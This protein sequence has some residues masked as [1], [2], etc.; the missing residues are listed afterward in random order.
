MAV[1]WYVPGKMNKQKGSRATFRSNNYRSRFP[2]AN[3]RGT[4]RRRSSSLAHAREKIS[5][6]MSPVFCRG[7]HE[8]YSAPT[9]AEQT[10]KGAVPWSVPGKTNQQ[11]GP[12]AHSGPIITDYSFPVPTA[13]EQTHDGAVPCRGKI[14]STS[15]DVYSTNINYITRIQKGTK[16]LPQSHRA[17][18]RKIFHMVPEHLAGSSSNKDIFPGTE[19]GKNSRPTV[20]G[21]T[22]GPST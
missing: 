20:P 9:S 16:F 5:T 6:K 10:Y 15:I 21:P 17:W 22:T 1:P 8:D 14:S 11:K 4:N 13:G 18:G 12:R 19:T 7:N 3:I 2:R